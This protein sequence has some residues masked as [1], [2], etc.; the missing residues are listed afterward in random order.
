[1]RAPKFWQRPDAGL[2]ARMLGPVGAL[3]GRAAARA[4]ATP[5]LDVGVPVLTIGN[6]T[7][8]GAG[9]TPTALALGRLLLASGEHPA[10]L[11]RGYGGT[12][13]LDAIEVSDQPAHLVGDEPLLLAEVAP[14][15]VGAMR[16]R[17]AHLAMK[18]M[19][20]SV[21]VCDDGLQ[22]RA[23]EPTLAIAVVDA[24]TGVGNNRCIPAGPLR[25]PLLRQI[26]H[27]NALVLIGAGDAGETV[28]AQAEA[29]DKPCFYADLEPGAEGRGLA[30]ERVVAFAGIGRPEKFFH[31]LERLGARI[32]AA[33]AFPDHHVYRL[34]DIERLREQARV[35]GALLVTT[36]KDAVRIPPLATPGPR[37]R[38]IPVRL[39]FRDPDSVRRFILDVLHKRR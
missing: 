34:R 28:A 10:F 18:S 35:E 23:L 36:E 32:I 4:M 22:S 1:M 12:G 33:R 15:F 16:V 21:L 13:S 3:V 20:P 27:I 19:R 31:M 29:L 38:A 24:E 30:G 14:T 2:R 5:G 9:K 7:V 25:A 17:A 39:V 11:S 37:P 6:F 26:G 8:G